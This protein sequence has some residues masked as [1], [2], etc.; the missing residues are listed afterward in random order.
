MSLDD[1]TDEE[2]YAYFFTE[3]DEEAFRVL[4]ER[5]GKLLTFFLK[6]LV[7]DPSDAEELMMDSFAAVISGNA[8]YRGGNNASFKT[9]LYAVAGNKARSHLRKKRWGRSMPSEEELIL[10]ERSLPENILLQEEK[11]RQLYL[12]LAGLPADQRGFRAFFIHI[13]NSYQKFI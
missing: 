6:E 8:R 13:K 9:F 5:H 7:G 3:G 1:R 11:N 4:F 12:A 10:Q 2:L